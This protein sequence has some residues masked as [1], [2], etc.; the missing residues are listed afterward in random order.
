MVC[1][2]SRSLYILL[3][4]HS[5]LCFKAGHHWRLPTLYEYLSKVICQTG[6]AIREVFRLPLPSSKRLSWL[7]PFYSFP[8]LPMCRH[9]DFELFVVKIQTTLCNL[10]PSEESFST[11]DVLSFYKTLKAQM[12]I[13]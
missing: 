1:T 2:Y 5:L 4:T 13:P 11:K 7:I 3:S 8:F 9:L 12:A 10:N 6:T